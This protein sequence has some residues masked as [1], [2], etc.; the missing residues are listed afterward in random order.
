MIQTV[1]G[2]KREYRGYE[3]L[4]LHSGSLGHKSF[5]VRCPFCRT[6]TIIYPWS[7]AGT[8]KRCPG[9]RAMYLTDWIYRVIA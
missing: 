3:V 7:V 1:A 6:E 5:W 8:G 4:G 9:C 2:Q